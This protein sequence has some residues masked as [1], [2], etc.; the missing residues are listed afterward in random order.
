MLDLD[1][2]EL[3]C[4]LCDGEFTLDSVVYPNSKGTEIVMIHNKCANKSGI[5]DK[6][7]E[8]MEANDSILKKLQ[9][10]T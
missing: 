4:I 6:L 7:G 2:E 1:G 9:D 3:R 5:V 8:T 10:I